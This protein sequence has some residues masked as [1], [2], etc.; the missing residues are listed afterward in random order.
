[1]IRGRKTLVGVLA[2]LALSASVR[3]V[4]P[5]SPDTPYRGIVER[6]VFGLKAP[7]DPNAFRPPP[8]PPVKITLTGIT[9]I[10]KRKCALLSAQPPNKPMESY[11]LAEGQ[12]D[13]DVEVL[14]IDEKAGSV[15]IN[16]HGI[17]QT[18]DFKT[19]GA[20]VQANP[21]LPPVN[22]PMG[23]M[24]PPTPLGMNP[25]QTPPPALRTIPTRTMRIPAIPNP[26]LQSMPENPQPEPGVEQQ[27][28]PQQ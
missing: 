18:L 26:Q 6:N 3:A 2:A 1:M 12:R 11:I 10:L 14:E 8:P 9:T 23:M 28:P 13:N 7:E 17:A 27:P 22:A 25:N 4:A 16:N 21:M 24:P 15:K 19:D 5:D 20:K